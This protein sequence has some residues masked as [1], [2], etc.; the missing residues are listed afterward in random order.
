[1]I[2]LIYGDDLEK[3]E[4][5]IIDLTSGNQFER[6]DG[7]KVKIADLE[8]KLLGDSLFG[9]KNIFLIEN[10]FKNKSKKDLLTIIINQAEVRIILVERVKLTKRD[11]GS[12]KFDSVVE[13]T[14]PQM[15]FKFLDDFYP[16]NSKILTLM[17]KQLLKTTTPEQI[18]YSLVKRIRTLIAVKT[19]TSN[20]S[21][22][23]RLAPWQISRLKSQSRLW[24]EN[25]L[26]SFYKKL[27]DLEVKMKSS[28]LPIALEEYL[29]TMIITELN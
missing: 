17:Y 29:D 10:I 7:S 5:S 2:T 19:N 23:I 28:Q 13:H 22:I 11:L 8:E 16:G 27:F 1:M 12:F 3:I 14:L 18:F 20:H 25:K 9:D 26:F 24:D 6:V 4:K 15:Y 21:E